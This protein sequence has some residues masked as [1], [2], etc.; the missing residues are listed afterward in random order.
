MPKKVLIVEDYEDARTFMKLLIEGYG[1]QVVEAADG[2]EALEKFKQQ[3][4]DLILMDISLPMV[5]GLTVTKAIRE[6]DDTSELPIIALTAFGKLYY[7]K[8]MEA[9]CNE[10]MNKPFDFDLLES[11]LS[12]YLKS[13][14]NS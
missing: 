1:Y 8:S 5:D 13:Q 9:G 12:R 4:P 7:K 3:Q 6:L 14:P 2:I 10:L 11:T